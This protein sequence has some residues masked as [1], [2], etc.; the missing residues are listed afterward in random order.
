MYVPV[1]FRRIGHVITTFVFLSLAMIACGG[2]GGGGAGGGGGGPNPTV[3]TGLAASNITQTQITLSWSASSD[4]S[5]VMG[6]LVSGG[7]P[8]LVT[9]GSTSYTFTNLTADT[10]YCLSV[11]A[12]DDEANFSGASSALCV[13]TDAPAAQPWVTVREGITD[14]LTRLVWTGTRLVAV[15]ESC[16]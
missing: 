9:A 15:A 12:F 1:T 7:V 5:M 14:P 2:G 3:P 10:Q 8:S 6:Y 13:T 16:S 11:E 4:D